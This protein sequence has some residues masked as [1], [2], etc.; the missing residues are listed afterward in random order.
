MSARREP[1]DQA[2][3]T[4]AIRARGV[5]VVADA[6]A[7]TG[8]TTLVVDRLVELVAPGDD[9]QAGVPLSR[10]AAITF[11]RKAAGELRLRIRE[12]LLRALA[13]AGLSETRRERLAAALA[14][15]D[16]AYVGTIHSFADRLLRLRPVE[17]WL[18]PSYEIV[19]DEAGLVAET[20]ALFL[21]AAQAGTLASELAGTAGEAIAAQAQATVVDA[22][23]AGIRAE[24]L[25]YEH[26]E[27]PGLDRLFERLVTTRDVPPAVPQARRPDHAR[28]RELVDELA[29]LAPGAG[30]AGAGSRFITR[31]VKRLQRLRDEQ[32]P[33]VVLAE[34]L[35]VRREVRRFTKRDDFP[36][37][38]AGWRAWKAFIG[39]GN[40]NPV[41][42]EPLSVD[43]V[44]PYARWMARRLVAIAPAVVAMYDEVKARHRAVDQVDLL[45]R[46]RDLVRD[47]LDVRAD[48]QALF[49]HVFVDEFQDTDPLQ[50]EIVLFLCE[51][52]ASARSWREVAVAPGKLTIVGDP[53]QSIYRFRRA[54]I[55]MY[56][57]VRE[58]LERGPHLVAKLTAN[59]RCEPDLVEWLNGRFDRL[60]G[61]SV[62]GEPVFDAAEG[63]VRN[64]RL[65]AGREGSRAPRV[66]VLKLAADPAR[67]PEYR[68][69]EAK[70]LGAWLRRLGAGGE[71]EVVDPAT[72]ARR[73]ARFGDV[74]VLV[75]S[76]THLPLLFAEL[77]R[78]GVP[79]AARGGQVFLGEPLHRQFLLA[80]RAIA[81]LDD[82]VAQAAL[83]RAPFFA[84]DYDD[85][86]R[87][88]A[89]D[90]SSTHA[91]V[92]RARAAEAFAQD[93]RRRRLERSPGAT[94][95]DL[96]EKT[97][98]G[99]HVAL[100][101][102]GAQRLDALR[103]LCLALDAVA[104]AE[105]LDY[106]GATARLRAWAIDPVQLDPPRPVG[107]DAVQVLSIHQAKG[108]EFP[109]VV[110]WDAC[111]DLAARDVRGAFTIDRDGASWALALDGIAWEEPEDADVA[112]RE[113]RYLD[114]ERRRLVYVA[115]TRAR[116]LLVL[117]VAGDPDPRRITGALAA[118]APAEGMEALEAYTVGA[119]PSWAREL[120]DPVAPARGD[121]SALAEA[122][123]AA[124]RSASE[125]AVAPRFAP[126]AVSG[127]AHRAAEPRDEEA[128]AVRPA[129][130]SRFGPVFGETVHRAIGIALAE[131]ALSPAAAVARAARATGLADRAG[132]AAADVGRALSALSAAGLRRAPGAD[133]QLEYPVAFAS[134]GK[135]L[136]GYVDLLAAEG[137]GVTVIDFKTDAP[138]QG[139]VAASH[140]AYVEQVRS[141]ARILRELGV[142][143]AVR[144]GLLFTAEEGIR[145]VTA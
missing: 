97:A 129:R 115:A 143:T 145:W 35:L 113:R 43:L 28:F 106:D 55:A 47:R 44:R 74:A 7:G 51:R 81:D 132:E 123:A 63:T 134:G 138:P 110:L 53:K 65:L 70:A 18:S 34:L 57:A 71:R 38:D 9:A 76:T 48:Y 68:A 46:L 142:A 98:F 8:K 41:R 79:Y 77:D 92:L 54:D 85:L 122:V 30:G 61:P 40:Q 66:R 109:V 22:L 136:S 130:T 19:E 20:F 39:D 21:Q 1:P 108:L 119:E 105:A 89:A 26:A 59:F 99:R 62:D 73:P 12:A 23:R 4:A 117:P 101:P 114:A 15:L 33:V 32:D 50:A 45:L 116:D 2:H 126:A 78:L 64:E 133:L 140:P 120:P 100:G 87:A 27:V 80:L 69:A 104:A 94:A 36:G 111:A 124:W 31:T 49:D 141:Y 37:D 24:T 128:G 125:A 84:L 131:P 112:A 60:L 96:L 82:G 118:G 95:R 83:L 135:L 103:E 29:A 42:D 16:T 67:K 5:N 86:A 88:R 13:G 102:N 14:Q 3:R 144:A 25:R 91:G 11:T 93:L 56:A 58:I 6:G 72:G 90:A 75:A 17:A 107:A 137:G 139:D 52:G 127:E 121:G 10:I